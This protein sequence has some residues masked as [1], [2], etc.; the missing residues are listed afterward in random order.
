MRVVRLDASSYASVDTKK[1]ITCVMVVLC[2]IVLDMMEV[3]E[4]YLS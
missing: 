2:A 4:H 1:T 3:F